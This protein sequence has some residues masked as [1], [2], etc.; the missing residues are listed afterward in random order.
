MSA[1]ATP[2]ST[3]VREDTGMSHLP[4][5]DSRRR[6]DEVQFRLV[7]LFTLPV[8]VLAAFVARLRPARW[9]SRNA[10]AGSRSSIFGEARAAAR[11][12]GSFALMG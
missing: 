8:F 6:A 9:K 12:C 5:P 4:K 11:T 7:Y 10:E 2:F 3:I 1:V